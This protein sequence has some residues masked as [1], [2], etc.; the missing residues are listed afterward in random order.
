MQTKSGAHLFDELLPVRIYD[1][2]WKP[3]FP[4]TYILVHLLRI[5]HVE[6]TPSATHLKEQD[7]E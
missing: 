4:K 5:F 2:V 3:N 1:I 6:R 7:T